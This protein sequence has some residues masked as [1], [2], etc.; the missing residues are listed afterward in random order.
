METVSGP[1]GFTGKFYQICWDIAGQH[2]VRMVQDSFNGNILFK[3]IT[4]TYLALLPKRDQVKAFADLRPIC[5]SNFIN[6]VI[7]RVVHDRIEGVLPK[8]I[9]SNQSDFVEITC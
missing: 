7:S 2:I 9:S 1:H 5:L 6:T 4:R 3:S 8:L